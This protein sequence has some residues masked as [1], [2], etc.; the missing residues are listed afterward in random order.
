MFTKENLENIPTFEDRHFQESLS[1]MSFMKEDVPQK[2]KSLK[3]NKS[4]GPDGHHPHVLKEMAEALAAPLT[5]VLSKILSTGTLLQ[6]W[7]DANVTP[8]FKKGKKSSP[9]NYIP[10]SLTSVIC[11]LM[12]SLVRDHIVKHMN[13][14]GLFLK[15]QHGFMEG[16]SCSTNL[17]ATLDVWSD[18]AENG[19]LVDNCWS[20]RKFICTKLDTKHLKTQN[21][22]YRKG[23]ENTRPTERP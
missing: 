11:K 1:D 7:K 10:V 3:I 21:K 23:N 16:Q 4:P 14:N 9:G 20:G 13:S 6:Q 17:L 19:I 2:L 8:I 22:D 5:L 15:Y 18:A 12:E